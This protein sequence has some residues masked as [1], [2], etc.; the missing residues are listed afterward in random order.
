MDK[1]RESS[2][3]KTDIKVS[4]TAPFGISEALDLIGTNKFIWLL[5]FLLGVAVVFDGYDYM[6]VSYTMAQ[7]SA[8]WGLD[9]VLTGSL[10][11]W[12]VVGIVLGSAISG[13]LSDR[14]GRKVTLIFSV[15]VFTCGTFPIYFADGFFLY[16]I[17]RMLAGLGIGACSPITL[18]MISE[19]APTNRRAV[20]MGLSAI[21]M[22]FGY[23]L[24]GVI[25]GL[26]IPVFGWR[27]CYLLGGVPFV[28][29]VVLIFTL[30]E[31]AHWLASKGRKRQAAALIGKIERMGKKYVRGDN[32]QAKDIVMPPEPQNVGLKAIFGKQYFALTIKMFCMYFMAY[33]IVYGINSWM[34]TLMLQRGFDLSTAY[35]YTIGQNVC[36][37]LAAASTGFV[38][39]A[40]GRRKTIMLGFAAS[41]L[42]IAAMAFTVTPLTILVSCLV[43]G[44]TRSFT[45]TSVQPFITECYRTEFR[46]T[47][48]SFVQGFGRCAG[49]VAPLIGGMMLSYGFGYVGAVLFYVVPAV[50]GLGIV[51]LIKIETRGKTLEAL[52]HEIDFGETP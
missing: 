22:T 28:Y 51:F 38:A 27:F 34:P 5:F 36:G 25:S 8:E 24:A 20:F 1:A 18:V 32:W 15:L 7:I 35:G 33:F 37:M 2:A 49:I 17:F 45:M 26:I 16:A 40:L 23:V 19:L 50:V 41:A 30:P 3:S 10:A 13:I 11:S 48:L 43:V 14:F 46:N 21:W 42:A 31:T 9:P 47:A 12:S 4:S 6:L 29:V 44:F 52:T 39:N